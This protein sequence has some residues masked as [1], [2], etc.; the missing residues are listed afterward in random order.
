MNLR[1]RFGRCP[2]QGGG[3]VLLIF[4]IIA[5]IASVGRVFSPCFVMQNVVFFLVMQSFH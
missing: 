1:R 5:P 2:L 4:F 3:S